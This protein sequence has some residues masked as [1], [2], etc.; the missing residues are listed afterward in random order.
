LLVACILLAGS[1][2]A[3][4]D[5]EPNDVISQAEGPIAG[6]VPV[7]GTYGTPDDFDYYVFYVQ[8]QQQIH[9]HQSTPDGCSALL[10]DTSG[11]EVP[12]DFT[13]PSGLNRYFVVVGRDSSFDDDCGGQS[14]TFQVDPASAIVTG[15]A[16][17]R[18]FV[19]TGE[20]NES[21]AQAGGPLAGG[22]NYRGSIDTDNDEDWFYFFV[23]PGVH[24]V[25]ATVTSPGPGPGGTGE[26]GSAAI[27]FPGLGEFGDDVTAS[28][29]EGS[30]GHVDLTFTGPSIQHIQASG[31]S[32][33]FRIDPPDA[34]TP[35]LQTPPPPPPARV[36]RAKPRVSAA[37]TRARSRASA[38]SRRVRTLSG[39]LRHAH[40][41][42]SR[43]VLRVYRKAA[44]THLGHA[45]AQR[46]RSCPGGR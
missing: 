21:Q 24:Q 17:D 3:L 32:W 19:Q 14:Y 26:C 13:T 46:H 7:A 1:A 10:L 8:G 31:C 43:H 39:Q 33:Q 22:V 41:G 38:W 28:G 27:S 25:E 40:G 34:L 20:P 29:S 15:P 12:E 16:I 36:V 5:V 42:H 18:S 9:L 30:F 11:N 44:R 4:A 45:L 2:C 23:A 37:C 35:T 6:G